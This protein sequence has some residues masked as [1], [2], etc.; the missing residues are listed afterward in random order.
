MK[1]E[2]SRRTLEVSTNNL[3]SAP[4]VN[5]SEFNVPKKIDVEIYGDAS[6]VDAIRESDI[7]LTVDREGKVKA[8]GPKGLEIIRITPKRLSSSS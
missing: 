6:L 1:K 2:S 4:G 8:D 5:L 3:S 7:Q